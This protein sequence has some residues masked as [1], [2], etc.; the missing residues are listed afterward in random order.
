LFQDNPD[1]RNAYR[2]DEI[3]HV[4]VIVSSFVDGNQILGNL[5]FDTSEK[6]KYFE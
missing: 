2:G 6:M 3:Q 4:D 1:Y 5:F